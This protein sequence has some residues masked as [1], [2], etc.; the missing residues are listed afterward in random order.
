MS[1]TI[2]IVSSLLLVSTA[3][4]TDRLVPSV[5]PTIQAGI[6]A[7]GTGDTVIVADEVYTGR[8][9]RDIDFN[10][11]AITVKSENGPENCIIDCQAL[12]YGFYF[13]NEEDESSVLDGFTISNGDNLA[14]GG[15]FCDSSPT[16]TNCTLTGNTASGR[17][18]AIYFQDGSPKLT[19]CTIIGN[20]GGSEG[21]GIY[22]Y[23]YSNPT[24]SNC[25]IMG[26]TAENGGGL[27]LYRVSP[28]ITN[29]AIA[30]NQAVFGGGI[31]CYKS[32]PLVLNC[33]ISGNSAGNDGGGIFCDN[34]SGPVLTSCI[35]W[36]NT[37]SGSTDESTQIHGGFAE[38][39]FSCIQDDA[40]NDG[41]IPFGG[42]S[43]GNIDDDPM[44]VR[45]PNDGSDGWGAGDND[46]F[47]DL[48]L[49]IGSPCINEGNPDFVAG[50][51]TDIDGQPRVI[52]LRVDMGA[53]EF[54]PMIVVTKPQGGEV[55]VSGSIHQVNWL[56]YGVNTAA[57]ILL[58]GM[59]LFSGVTLYGRLLPFRPGTL[60]ILRGLMSR[61]YRLLVRRR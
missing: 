8:G 60:W 35:L 43:N 24:I 37:D 11:K 7:S 57:Y 51:Q 29:C 33:T 48:H 4:A 47:G 39:S 1:R 5:Y 30:G 53:D 14:G 40:P 44:F 10:G 16:I 59:V 19:N 2:L 18:G 49:Q 34:Y 26:N 12:G 54:E 61:I 41:Y 3:F 32:S 15:I 50:N 22:C 21:G 36:V 25:T 55:W 52:G 58:M 13:H 27:Y 56:S 38:P 45:D 17:G 31:Y 46:D 9:N 28:T 20:N 23:R 6:N 42:E